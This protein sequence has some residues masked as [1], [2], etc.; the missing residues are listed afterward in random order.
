MVSRIEQIQNAHKI[1][2]DDA[3]LI[4]TFRYLQL[5]RTNGVHENTQN[6]MD[7]F[8]KDVCSWSNEKLNGFVELLHPVSK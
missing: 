2:E 7:D 8:C 1:S 4:L 6:L 3:R 5:T